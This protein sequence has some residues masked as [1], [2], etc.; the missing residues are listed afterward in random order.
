MYANVQYLIWLHFGVLSD[1]TSSLLSIMWQSGVGGG[2][3]H[4]EGGSHVEP[5]LSGTAAASGLL[6]SVLQRLLCDRHNTPISS[7]HVWVIHRQKHTNTTVG[8]GLLI[9]WS[10]IR[11]VPALTN[12]DSLPGSSRLMNVGSI[13]VRRRSCF[14]ATPPLTLRN[15]C[16]NVTSVFRTQ[17]VSGALS[18]KCCVST[19]L[20]K[21]AHQTELKHSLTSLLSGLNAVESLMF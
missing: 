16:R 10:R 8:L 4:A 3:C 11:A 14:Q 19:N 9:H 13:S 17:L 12:V 21:Q 6:L 1:A 7:A 20:Q 18:K 2:R 15:L 5:R